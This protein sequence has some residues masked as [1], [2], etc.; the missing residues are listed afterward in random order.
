M[1]E[2]EGSGD[3]PPTTRKPSTPP[4]I[5]PTTSPRTSV[6]PTSSN[7][8]GNV[9][10]KDRYTAHEWLTG[11][12]WINQ[13]NDITQAQTLQTVAAKLARIVG[14]PKEAKDAATA[15]AFC[16][17]GMLDKDEVLAEVKS[18]VEASTEAAGTKIAEAAAEA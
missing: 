5:T 15:L 2:S 10:I 11:K 3:K 1:N 8:R 17:E 4:D 12:K 9:T 7:G 6:A 16:L 13:D 14:L 18:S